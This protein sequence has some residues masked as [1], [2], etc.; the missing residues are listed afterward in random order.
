MAWRSGAVRGTAC[1]LRRVVALLLAAGA[2][3]LLGAAPAAAE[4]TGWPEPD[5]AQLPANLQKYDPASAAWASAPWMTSPTCKDKGGD[6]S[7]WAINVM[8]DADKLLNFFGWPTDLI[9]EGAKHYP[10]LAQDMIPTVPAGYC[11][12]DMKLW[13]GENLAFKPFGFEWGTK[14]HHVGLGRGCVWFADSNDK[15]EDYY[16]KWFGAERA[17]CYGFYVDCGGATTDERPRCDAWNAFSDTYGRRA[18]EDCWTPAA[19]K[20]PGVIRD[21]PTDTKIKSP[22]E[23]VGDVALGWFSDLTKAIAEGSLKLLAEAMTFWTKTDRS[24]MLQSPAIADI[25]GMLRWVSLA[26]L[27]GSLIWQGIMMILRRKPDPLVGAGM[28]LLSYAGW[29]T[30]GTT[31]TFLLYEGGNAL[32]TQVLGHAIDKFAENIGIAVQST[33][34][35]SVAIVFFLAIILFFLACIQWALGFFRMGALVVVVALIPTAAAGQI[36]EA[37]KPWLRKVLTWALS[38]VMYQPAAAV[39]FAIGFVLMGDAKDLGTILTGMAVLCLAVFSMPTMLRFFDWGG[40]RFV[41]AGGGG[42]G[43]MAAGA[44][45]SVLAGGGARAFGG[46]MDRSGPGGRGS[47]QPSSGA[48]PVASA[49]TGQGPGEPGQ[50]GQRPGAGPNGSPG[51]GPGAGGGSPRPPSTSPTP[52]RVGGGS[53]IGAPGGATG[54]AS[55]GGVPG[56]GGGAAG[57][58]AAATGAA[59]T[60]AQAGKNAAAGAMT[61]SAPSGGG[62]S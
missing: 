16:N 46:Y 10:A 2:L 25:Q 41:S 13:A 22:G 24:S 40:Q 4:P 15:E 32:A 35:V 47:T 38:L 19:Q 45:A 60:A 11:V 57:G 8:T 1:A 21:A 20:F 12:D 28:G 9:R 34:P 53:A 17:P 18:N 7:I 6:F 58:A 30:L 5:L 23:I 39:I 44:A 62:N 26:V 52:A 56:G 49:N 27:I 43:A 50:G 61:D 29:S 14:N 48:A 42:G 33:L 59:V 36:N 54:G 55:G 37:T 31:A 51:G 3:A